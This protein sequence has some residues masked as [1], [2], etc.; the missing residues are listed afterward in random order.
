MVRLS[1][2]APGK[3][4]SIAAPFDAVRRKADFPDGPLP[5]RSSCS[6]RSR[7]DANPFDEDY[8]FP[9]S[10]VGRAGGTVDPFVPVNGIG[11]LVGAYRSRDASLAF[12]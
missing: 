12:A 3:L 4:P 8:G 5:F 7:F 9:V 11:R 2:F 6:D 1:P 10:Y